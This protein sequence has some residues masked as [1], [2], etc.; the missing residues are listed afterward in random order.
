MIFYKGDSQVPE[1]A[2]YLL[3][4]TGITMAFNLVYLIV[5]ELFPTIFRATAYG[6]C[7]VPGRLITIL[8]PLVAQLPGLLPLGILAIFS[9]IVSFLPLFLKRVSN[10]E[11]MHSK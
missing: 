5:S 11:L 6:V 1:A 3:L 8:S 7:N 4:Y 10:E 2:L 9:F